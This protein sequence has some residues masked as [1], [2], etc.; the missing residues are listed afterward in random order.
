MCQAEKDG[1]RSRNVN[2]GTTVQN[3]MWLTLYTHNTLWHYKFTCTIQYL[4]QRW[5]IFKDC[6]WNV[7]ILTEVF[8]LIINLLCEYSS[9]KKQIQDFTNTEAFISDSLGWME[10]MSTH[11]TKFFTRSTGTKR[12]SSE[13]SSKPS[14]VFTA[15][16]RTNKFPKGRK[17][18]EITL[19]ISLIQ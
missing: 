7:L 16:Q 3:V 12:R 6:I 5:I 19:F 4:L 14:R 2:A 10:G 13:D 15:W 8:K 11:S 9:G 1:E 17:T 18:G